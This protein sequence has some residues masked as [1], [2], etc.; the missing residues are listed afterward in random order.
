[1]ENDYCGR[2]DTVGVQWI[3]AVNVG[4]VINF[5]FIVSA[6]FPFYCN[7]KAIKSTK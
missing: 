6:N 7:D 2:Q 1:M 4:F 3:V 5:Q